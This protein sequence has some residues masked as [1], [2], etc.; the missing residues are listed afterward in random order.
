MF[1]LLKLLFVLFFG[2]GTALAC[3]QLTGVYNCHDDEV[4]TY[5]LVVNQS[6]SGL[7]TQYKVLDENGDEIFNFKADNIWRGD[8][9]D[10]EERGYCSGN[11]AIYSVRVNIAGGQLETNFKFHKDKNGNL[12]NILEATVPGQVS[13]SESY[14]CKVN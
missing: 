6:G 11:M 2:V 5:S 3:P 7:N 13:H 4:G 14:T 8:E 9:I 10:G 12:V 1:K